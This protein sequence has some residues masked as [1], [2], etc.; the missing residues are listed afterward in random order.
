MNVEGILSELA[1]LMIEVRWTRPGDAQALTRKFKTVERKVRIFADVPDTERP[2]I[3]QSEPGTEYGQ[4]TGMPYKATMMVNWILY[5]SFGKNN[6]KDL[7]TVEN[8]VI[9]EG[10]LNALAPKTT[11]PGFYERRN[12]LGGLVHHCFVSGRVFKE[13]GDIDGDA[14]MIVPIKILVP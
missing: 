8:N 13:A 2:Y 1:K 7:G 11:D 3:C 4:M 6:R 10:I 14:M 12:T 9:E 5:H